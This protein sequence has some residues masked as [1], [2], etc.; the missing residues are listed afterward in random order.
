MHIKVT[1]TTTAAESLRM[2]DEKAWLREAKRE[3][4]PMM[5]LDVLYRQTRATL[6]YTYVLAKT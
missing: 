4:D 1:I 6:P 2:G 5:G 3:A